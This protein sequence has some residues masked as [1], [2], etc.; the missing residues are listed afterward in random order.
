MTLYR[1]ISVCFGLINWTRFMYTLKVTQ[2][3][4]RY[5]SY[6]I[7]ECSMSFVYVSLF[8]KVEE[9]APGEAPNRGKMVIK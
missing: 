1:L 4:A 5:L 3:C 2:F 7:L 6:Y 8:L 9:R